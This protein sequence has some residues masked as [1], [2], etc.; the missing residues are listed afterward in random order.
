MEYAVPQLT[1]REWTGGVINTELECKVFP[2]VYFS[3]FFLL[4]F[5]FIFFIVSLI[6]FSTYCRDI[7]RSLP[8][9]LQCPGH[10]CLLALKKHYT[11]TIAL[12]KTTFT[13]LVATITFFAFILTQTRQSF[14]RDPVQGLQSF[15]WH[16]G[17][18]IPHFWNFGGFQCNEHD[19]EHQD[20]CKALHFCVWVDSIITIKNKQTNITSSQHRAIRPILNNDYFLRLFI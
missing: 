15:I 10:S 1:L 7:H 16:I 2:K 20:N 17:C 8:W 5:Y 6:S 12:M 4:F 19:G 13:A 18:Y 3:H 9:E 11:R 14:D